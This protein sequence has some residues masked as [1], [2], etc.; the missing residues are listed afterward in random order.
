[1]PVKEFSYAPNAI[2][3]LPGLLHRLFDNES[4]SKTVIVADKRTNEAAGRKVIDSLRKDSIKTEIIIVPDNGDY[5]PVCDDKTAGWLKDKIGDLSVDL[6]IAVGSG[7]IN[8]L[9]K[10]SS[11]EL[12]LP[13]IV[14]AT[15]ASMNGYA[16]AN[17]AAKVDGVKVIQSARPPV[18]VITEPSIIENAP[19][20]MTAAGFGDIIAR[21]QSSADWYINHLIFGEYYCDFC[22]RIIEHLEP[23]YRNNPESIRNQD[24]EAIKYL[25]ESLFYS[26]IAMTLAGTSSPASGGEHLFSH[27][28]DMLSDVDGSRHDLHGRQV[29]L[30]VIISAAV[31]QKILDIDKPT[32]NN[33]IPAPCEEVWGNGKLYRA[34][35]RQFA[36]KRDKLKQVKDKLS[37]SKRWYEVKEA[38]STRSLEPDDVRWKLKTAGAACRLSDIGCSIPRARRVMLNMHQIRERFTVVDLGWRLGVLPESVGEIIKN[39]LR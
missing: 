32:F 8:D 37:D 15:A 3:N 21:Q 14:V 29:G 27:T 13:Y 34:V 36:G 24:S 10:W 30:G 22:A 35:S 1:M 12:G 19:F 17:V 26:G 16:A 23:Y 5:S 31:Y 20:E 39:Y 6:V 28:L 25:F 11:Y 9:C 38:I 18:A 33:D 4:I 2:E 7:V